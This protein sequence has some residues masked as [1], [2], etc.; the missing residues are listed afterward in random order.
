[1]ESRGFP[2]TEVLAK[3]PEQSWSQALGQRLNVTRFVV[4]DGAFGYNAIS[5]V[6]YAVRE[7]AW[8]LFAEDFT[9]GGLTAYL[10]AQNAVHVL[11]Y[12]AL[13]EDKRLALAAFNPE[14]ID[15]GDR[16]SN[17]VALLD[18]LLSKQAATQLTLTNGEFIER[19][20]IDG[21]AR[22]PIML[23]GR[24]NVPPVTAD[25]LRQRNIQYGV[26]IGSEQAELGRWIKE[27]TPMKY[28][29]VKFAQTIIE[30]GT[31]VA[32]PW[33]L[34]VFLVP[35]AALNV[36]I[37]AIQYNQKTSELEVVYQNRESVRTY[38][39]G[40]VDLLIGNVS[41]EHVEDSGITLLEA[42][43][44]KTA[45]YRLTTASGLLTGSANLSA[46]VSGLYG[47]EPGALER[48]VFQR[49]DNL[50]VI[51]FSDDSLLAL[52]T[53]V[54]D[55]A[56]QGFELEIINSG[57][58]TAYFE[59]HLQ[60]SLAD[61]PNALGT[62]T[63]TVPAGESQKVFFHSPFS[64]EQLNELNGAVIS[65][66]VNYGAREAFLIKTVSEDRLFS[67]TDVAVQNS[68]DW[69]LIAIVGLV[70][71]GGLFLF[72]RRG[73]SDSGGFSARRRL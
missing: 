32:Q 68:V 36:S 58:V 51:S 47:E 66:S 60:F 8:V 18:R 5:V 25:F 27:N 33:A 7:N 43:A 38:L 57:P 42:G 44:Q 62:K 69:T 55:V 1:L 49:A 29:Y 20:L 53:L 31:A 73:K 12:G 4:L 39:K 64:K 9:P 56:R 2:V 61:E 17:N 65:T 48:L 15:R 16:F 54:Y 13:P 72:T 24:Q 23:T 35:R 37:N 28:I 26:L 3:A 52:G 6:S 22:D 19:S 59:P 30:P 71:A 70:V 50:A 10:Q 40:S 11:Q 41:A 34:N 67:L 14:T 63:L 45:T 21:P 46:E